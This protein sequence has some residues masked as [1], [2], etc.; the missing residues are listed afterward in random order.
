MPYEDRPT[1]IIDRPAES[2]DA[3]GQVPDAFL[4]S[5]IFHS[6]VSEKS[7]TKRAVHARC[8]EAGGRDPGLRGP[9]APLQS[10]YK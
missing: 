1:E 6:D 5:R 9:A 7:G 4:A 8:E 2:S 3:N 10:G